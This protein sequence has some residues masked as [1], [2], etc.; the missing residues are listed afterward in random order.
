LAGVG[1]DD[2]RHQH[3]MMSES[4]RSKPAL[5]PE[6]NVGAKV[7]LPLIETSEGLSRKALEIACDFGF[8]IGR[9]ALHNYLSSLASYCLHTA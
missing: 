1:R 2:G 8:V 6:S 5:A 7:K 3:A 4:I 9:E